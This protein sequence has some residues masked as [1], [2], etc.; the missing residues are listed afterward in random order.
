MNS[1]L[2]LAGMAALLISLITLWRTFKVG[3]HDIRKSRADVSSQLQELVDKTA[4]RNVE[5]TKRVL[6]FENDKALMLA[7]LRTLLIY[8]GELIAHPRSAAILSRGVSLLEK[9]N[10]KYGESQ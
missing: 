6:A 2:D 8:T 10:A 1:S 7:D 5:L 3:P 9:F 4:C